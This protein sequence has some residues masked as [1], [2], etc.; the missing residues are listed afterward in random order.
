MPA[1]L[2]DI[3]GRGERAM[4]SVGSDAREGPPPI[5]QQAVGVGPAKALWSGAGVEVPSGWRRWNTAGEE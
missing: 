4:A 5:S 2:M 3:F 1:R